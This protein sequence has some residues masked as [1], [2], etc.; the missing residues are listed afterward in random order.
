MSTEPT[1]PTLS[2]A[3]AGE[4]ATG[5]STPPGAPDRLLV[6]ISNSQSHLAIDLEAVRRLVHGTLALEGVSTAS[7]SIA[8]VD[9][10]T[11][12]A[13][14]RRHL[15][16][17][18]PTDIITFVLSDEDDE[19]L[20][21][22]LVVSAEMAVTTAREASVPAW[23]ELALYVVHGLLHVCGH[24]DTTPEARHE[25]RQR[26]GEVLAALGLSNTFAA[27]SAHVE[28]ADSDRQAPVDNVRGVA[29]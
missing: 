26:E 11:I 9:D 7:I 16:H 17:D 20:A 25:M 27:V 18:W 8:F 4:T 15:N 23:D 28:P 21:A 2:N 22:E 12:H 3:G 6:E 29:S 1:T 13:L 5:G 19:E 24:D 10:P 14:N